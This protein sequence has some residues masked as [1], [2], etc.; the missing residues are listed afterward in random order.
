MLLTIKGAALYIFSK[1][2]SHQARKQPPLQLVFLNFC[3]E[4]RHVNTVTVHAH[5]DRGQARQHRITQHGDLRVV[6]VSLHR[7]I[8][9][10]DYEKRTKDQLTYRRH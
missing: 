3:L 8:R 9:A 10:K 6:S 2:T 1:L 7:K 4:G 5:R